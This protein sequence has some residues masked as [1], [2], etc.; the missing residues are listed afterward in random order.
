[1]LARERLLFH[2]R[3]PH[4]DIS[5]LYQKSKIFFMPSRFESFNIAAA[6]ALCCGCSVV[7]ANDV[8]SVPFFASQASGTGACRLTKAHLL[9]ALSAEME[10][11]ST[12]QRDPEKISSIWRSIVGTTAVSR[13]ILRELENIGP[14]TPHA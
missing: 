2:G 4:R 3:I 1:V 6:E 10:A 8:A 14:V 11:R 5:G 7:G 9:D 13:L 12:G